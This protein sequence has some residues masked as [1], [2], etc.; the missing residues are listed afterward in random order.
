M[1]QNEILFNCLISLGYAL[2]YLGTQF[3]FCTYIRVP[4][5]HLGMHFLFGVCE[6]HNEVFRNLTHIIV[7]LL[8]SMMIKQWQTMT[9]WFSKLNLGYYWDNQNHRVCELGK[10]GTQIKKCAYPNENCV[11]NKKKCVPKWELG[12]QI[13]KCVPKCTY[14]DYLNN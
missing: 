8:H 4:S 13:R 9:Q 12:T 5:F 7:L 14:C 2:F 3:S 1:F 11:P 10:L 6:L